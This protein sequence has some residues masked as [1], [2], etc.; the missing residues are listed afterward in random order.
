MWCVPKE[1]VTDEQLQTNIDYA[2][3]RGIDCSPIAPGGACF[4]PDTL[5]SHAAYAMNLHYQTN[6]RNAWDCDFSKTATL[7]SKDP[8]KFSLVH[9]HNFFFLTLIIYLLHYTFSWLITMLII[10]SF[11]I[12]RL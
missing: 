9:K 7:S 2:C 5:A 3:G 1:G 8:S 12:C 10:H 11:V 4:E 6:G